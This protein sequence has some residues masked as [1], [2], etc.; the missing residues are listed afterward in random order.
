MILTQIPIEPW[1]TVVIPRRG[2]ARYGLVRFGYFGDVP[3][4]GLCILTTARSRFARAQRWTRCG[5]WV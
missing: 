4:V 2:L 1:S 3:W 5:D